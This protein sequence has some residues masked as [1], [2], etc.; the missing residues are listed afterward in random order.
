MPLQMM[1][2]HDV[3]ARNTMQLNLPSPTTISE[4]RRL[5]NR[6]AQRRFRR[7][8]ICVSTCSIRHSITDVGFVNPFVKNDAS[9]S[10]SNNSSKMP[11]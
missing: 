3:P 2:F 10:N 1:R 4:R 6:N 5:Q 11:P 9:S 8:S 7:M